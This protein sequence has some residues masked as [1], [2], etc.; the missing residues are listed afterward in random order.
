MRR[1]YLF[2]GI[3]LVPLL[4]CGCRSQ[5]PKPTSYK[6]STQQKMQAAQHWDVLAQ[7]VA[8]QIAKKLNNRNV[9][10]R[11]PLYVQ[12]DSK[13]T[14]TDAFYDLLVGHLID[15]GVPVTNNKQGAIVAQYDVQLIRHSANNSQRP[16]PGTHTATASTISGGI[17]VARNISGE[18]AKRVA[19]YSGGILLGAA[20]DASY[21]YHVKLPR[22]EVL[23]TT[24]L[25]QND[26]LVLKNTDIYYINDKDFW[27]Y[28]EHDPGKEY[29]VSN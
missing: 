7:D 9:E 22:N 5:V 19:A 3:A 15:R 23:I 25:E 8:S 28:V 24:T 12:N 16:W 1:L 26:R 27:H 11:N 10:N 13:L 6:F 20:I 14:F 18:V 21:G 4:F 2:L 29:T 17:E